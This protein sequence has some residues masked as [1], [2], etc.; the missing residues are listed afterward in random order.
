MD[1][2]YRDNFGSIAEDTKEY[3]ELL[4]AVTGTVG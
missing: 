4:Q 1:S 3:P 2:G